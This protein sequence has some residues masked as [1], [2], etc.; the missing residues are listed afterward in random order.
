MIDENEDKIDLEELGE[1]KVT[2][3]ESCEKSK[4]ILANPI[5]DTDETKVCI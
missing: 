3:R 1:D 4:R 5:A 2:Q